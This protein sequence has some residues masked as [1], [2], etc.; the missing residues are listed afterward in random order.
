MMGR[1]GSERTRRGSNDSEQ[2]Q[3]EAYSK[4]ARALVPDPVII[5]TFDLGGDKFPMFLHMPPEEN[6]FLGWRAIR[7][8]LDEPELFRTQL[9]AILRACPAGHEN[10]GQREQ[11]EGYRKQGEPHGG[12][13]WRVPPTE[14]TPRPGA[15][16]G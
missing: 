8:C 3:T 4:V 16:A 13:L 10:P 15:V 1:V 6:P 11:S 5:R 9:R 7:V 2:E 14:S 12:P